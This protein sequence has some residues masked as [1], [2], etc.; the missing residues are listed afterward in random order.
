MSKTKELCRFAMPTKTR[1][2]G[3]ND[4]DYYEDEDDDWDDDDDNG[5]DD[6][7]YDE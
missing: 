4:Y 3:P 7:D 6:D 1:P 5:D 2:G